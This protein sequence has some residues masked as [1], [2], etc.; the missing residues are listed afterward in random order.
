VGLVAELIAD[1]G[2]A[3]SSAGDFFRSRGFLA[4]EGTTHTLRL[5][6]EPGPTSVPLIVREIEGAPE[7]DA[8]SPY[9]YPGASVT[10]DD[11]PPDPAAIDWSATGLVSVFGRERLDGREWV[12]GARTLSEV[13]MH[14]PTAPR[15]IRARLT[16]QIRANARDG[17]T[18]ETIAGP[19][20]SALQRDAF[21]AGYA[22]TM[23][24][25]GAAE[26]YFFA[27]P[28]F[29][30]ALDF[31]RSWLV[32][33]QRRGALGAAAIAA[34][35]DGMLHY[36]LGGTA[37]CARSDSPFKNVVAAMLDLAD[38]LGMPLNLGGG[39][40]PGDG[41]ERFKRGFANATRDFRVHELVCDGAAYDR[42]SSGREPGAT[43]AWFPAY[44]AP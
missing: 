6:A 7:L 30:A 41:L 34:V 38:E 32:A 10:G 44:R 28:Y 14:D 15:R 11:A 16:E 36:F 29:D 13:Q 37:D 5:A 2:A 21:A 20:S 23:Q 17:W 19:D 4:A 40:Q 43:G 26:R 31:E 24:R 8:S 42:L 25:A 27:R 35:S 33:C 1:G 22:Q 12:A 9:G 18:V 39:V 3:A